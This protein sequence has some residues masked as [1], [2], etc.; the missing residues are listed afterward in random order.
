MR[1]P[2][3]AEAAVAA[4]AEGPLPEDAIRRGF[5]L[6]VVV[7]TFNERD[8]VE[9]VLERL[10]AALD[11]IEWE[12]VYV[13]DDSPDGTAD[14]VRAL[15]QDHPRVRCLQRI[16][17]RGLSAAVIEGMLSSS[18]PFFA[19][20]DADLQHDAALLPRML[21][22]LKEE[23]LDIV[24]GSR[25]S[26]GGGV[27]D[28]DRRRVA[29]SNVAAGLARLVVAADLTDPMSGFFILSRPAFERAV[30]RLSGQGFKIL[31]DLFASTPVAFR[32]KEMPYVFGRRQHGE[33]KLDSF[34][35]W[36]YLMLLADKLVG[37]YVP[38][39]FISFAAIGGFGVVVHFTALY[40]GL[41][42]FAFPLAQAVATVV[43][44]TSN[45]ALNNVLTYRDRRLAGLR[46]VTGLVSFYAVCSLGAVANV[47]IASA[48]FA[49]H[50][51]WWASGLA[52]A[53][54]GVVWN[55][56]VSSVLT[57]KRS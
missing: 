12:V 32:F 44:M 29:I 26:P 6:T 52:G 47:G 30:R 4:V 49:D 20:I 3:F 46:F 42:L 27:G 54:V 5:E 39:R 11:G 48:A 2:S 50:Y 35:I 38:A 23:A 21:A 53:V 17:R 9:L 55:Y 51:T 31:L 36:E 18:A 43:A 37:G 24:V 7:P 19:V 22:A 10:D 15:A 8:N 45:F 41:K 25:R 33:S 40:L 34:V 13:D 28:W 14:K 16:G 57:W 56:A 1:S